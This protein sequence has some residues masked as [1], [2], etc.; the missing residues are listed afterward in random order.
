[1]FLEISGR[2]TG[3]TTRLCRDIIK[4]LDS[5]PS[6]IATIVC[7]HDAQVRQLYH[8]ILPDV[9]HDR[10]IISSNFKKIVES[11]VNLNTSSLFNYFSRLLF[12][13]EVDLFKDVKFYFDE[14]DILDME[15]VPIIENAYYCTSPSRQRTLD[16]WLFWRSDRLLRLIVNND[17]LYTSIHG[18]S[19]IIDGDLKLDALW[20]SKSPDIFKLDHLSTLDVA[21]WKS[22]YFNGNIPKNIVREIFSQ[23]KRTK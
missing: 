2:R 15:N 14:V 21:E 3:K 11:V 20:R 12:T 17:F 18:M 1:M 7:P 23:M 19:Q 4:H 8:S 22:D 10:V 5:K 9:Y 13:M 6:A 16:D